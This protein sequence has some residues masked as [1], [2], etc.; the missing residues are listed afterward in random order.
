MTTADS[1][2]QESLLH[3]QDYLRYWFAR[4]VSILGSQ[5]TYVAF[6]LMALSTFQSAFAAS[7]VTACSYGSTL[8][9]GVHAGV[10]ADRFDRKWLMVVVEVVQAVVMLAMAAMLLIG[11]VPLAGVCLVAFVNGALFAVYAS[12]SN[13]ALPDLVGQDLL[14]RAIARNQMRD[15]ALSV[16]GPPA[17]GLL[18]VWSIE[19][20]FLFNA[21]TLLVAAVL[22]ATVRRSLP[23][24][25]SAMR[26]SASAAGVRIVLGDRVL[27]WATLFL[28]GQ[29]V[30]LT[31]SFF[32]VVAVL[33]ASSSAVTTGIALA[34]QAGGG[35]VGSLAA[36]RIHA[37]V[38]GT[39][40]LLVQGFSW[41]AGLGLLTVTVSPVVVC[42]VLGFMW[43]TVPATRIAF[44][45]HLTAVTPP[46]VRGRV[47]SVVFLVQSTGTAIGPLLAGVLIS[48]TSDV[49]TLLV[50]C[51]ISGTVTVFCVLLPSSR[52][53]L[54]WRRNLDA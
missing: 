12:C 8:M 36:T 27:R 33:A 16:A 13:A 45:T 40:L 47:Q 18:V 31:S 30:V 15:F 43:L 6:P 1:V 23:P 14:P 4:A 44:Q 49:S 10:L 28:A 53:R 21:A 5:A 37:R 25:D 52:A 38:G 19:A 2:G 34:C 7:L 26:G 32:A 51:L 39:Q 54:M 48:A 42:I 29:S 22:T 9:V 20:P 35:L 24:G 50:T 17:G 11:W 46:G 3:N 41:T